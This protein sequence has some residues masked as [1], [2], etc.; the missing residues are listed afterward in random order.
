MS[1]KN[2][3]FIAAVPLM[4]CTL[5]AVFAQEKKQASSA[6]IAKE[7]SLRVPNV[8]DTTTEIRYFLFPEF[9]HFWPSEKNDT[10]LR[11]EC[12]GAD[13]SFIIADTMHSTTGIY[14]IYFVKSFINYTHTYIDPEGKPKPSAVTKT[15]YRYDRTGGDMWKGIDVSSNFVSELKEHIGEIVRMDT[16]VIVNPVTGNNQLTIRKYYRVEELKRKEEI[17]IEN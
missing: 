17:N 14:H 10:I 7:P 16:T 11:Y 4:L 3:G 9:Y 2:T 8:I 13:N 6:R 15:I 5:F 1:K 12:Y